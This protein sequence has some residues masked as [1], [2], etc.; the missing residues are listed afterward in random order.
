MKAR[1]EWS[2][3][4]GA[5]STFL[6]CLLLSSV[7]VLASWIFH[8]KM[9]DEYD[10]N[11]AKFR[12][13]SQKYLSVDSDEKI[14]RELYPRFIELYNRGIIG[15]EK[16]LNWVET[17][18]AAGREIKLPALRYQIESRNP[19]EP[20][21][22]LDTGAYKLYVTK[23]KL[24]LGLL[25]EIDLAKFFDNLNKNASGLYTVKQCR[26]NRTN[27]EIKFDPKHPNISADCELQWFSLNLSDG[28]EI[29][30]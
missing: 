29:K 6:L 17:L 19:F 20:E 26:F 11:Q 16:R 15:S 23:M 5:I 8:N 22:E 25:H 28:Q 14:I 21:F 27:K 9:K 10:F 24:N 7:L 18:E 12:E 13:V 30:L 1:I 4:R 3:L 2:M